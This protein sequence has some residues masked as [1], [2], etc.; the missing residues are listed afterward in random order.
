TLT[1]TLREFG[2]M[3][4]IITFK[5][6]RQLAG[7]S[8]YDINRDNLVAK[9]SCQKS[10]IYG[11]GKMKLLLIDC[12]LKY[13]QIKLLLKLDTTVI[14]VP[15]NFNPFKAR[16]Q[17]FKEIQGLTPFDAIIISNGPGDPKK[18]DKTIDTVRLAIR[19]KIPILGICLG[20]QI[21]ALSAGADTYKLKYGHRSQNQPVRDEMTGKCYITTQNHGFA[22]DTKT[23]SSGWDPWFTNLNDQTNEGVRHR[24]L[25]FFSTQF[26][27]E[28]T[29]GPT[30]TEWVFNYFIEEASRF[31]SSR[32][33]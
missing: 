17:T 31:L 3:K 9:V 33:K 24:R 18:A 29:P 4:G 13:S 28:G 22:V 7:I 5:D 16:G 21:L 27:P 1:K 26:H 6:P 2:V 11:N 12:G 19:N 32:T 20:N 15:W 10:V 30:D 8:F 14:R 25:P 23:L